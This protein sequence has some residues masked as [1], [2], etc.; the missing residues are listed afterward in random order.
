L[1]DVYDGVCKKLIFRH[2]HIFADASVSD[3]EEVLVNWD[4]LKKEEKG[5]KSHTDT[6]QAVAKNLPATW[7]TEKLLKKAAKAG[8]VWD[9]PQEA[10]RKLQE[11]TQEL[12]MVMDNQDRLA[13]ELGDVLFAAVGVAHMTGFDPEELLHRACEKFVTRFTSMEAA[14]TADLE[15]L[16][17]DQLIALWNAAKNSKH[18]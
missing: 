13:E 3:A 5:Q 18:N 9:T 10:V 2:P 16:S 11:E 12:A 1:D 14:A 8:F 15:T 4:A 17:K 7:R 6:L